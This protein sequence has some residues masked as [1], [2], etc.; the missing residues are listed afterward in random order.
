MSF[1]VYILRCADNSYY[2]GH[3]DNLEDRIAKHKAGEID[4]YTSTRLPVSVVFSEEFPTREEAL[5]C[6]QQIKSEKEGSTDTKGLGRDIPA[7]ATPSPFENLR[8]TGLRVYEI[9]AE[10]SKSQTVLNITKMS[11]RLPSTPPGD[12]ELS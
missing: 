9:R 1:W 5:A 6:E 3:T 11:T 4:G 2:T 8:V 12:I 7:C 10:K